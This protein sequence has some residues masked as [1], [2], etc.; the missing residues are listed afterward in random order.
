MHTPQSQRS[1]GVVLETWTLATVSLPYPQ[2]DGLSPHG[3]NTVDTMHLVQVGG[4]E[5]LGHVSPKK[6]LVV[7]KFKVH[8]V[9]R[10]NFYLLLQPVLQPM[11]EHPES[12]SCDNAGFPSSLLVPSEVF[13]SASCW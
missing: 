8:W 13:T 5:G 12:A 10:M 9:H 1:G 11:Y 7:Y 6:L 2:H 3:H 4:K